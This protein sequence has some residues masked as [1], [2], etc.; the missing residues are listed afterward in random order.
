MP[1]SYSPQSQ[2]AKR[3]VR[4]TN[5]D[6]NPVQFQAYSKTLLQ[7]D[8]CNLHYR[9]GRYL[10]P[11]RSAHW[12]EYYQ[13]AIWDAVAREDGIIRLERKQVRRDMRD[14]VIGLKRGVST[15]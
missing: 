8:V 13:Q 4:F 9:L 14:D 7:P 5:D 3:H 6:D 11:V 1:H 10:F 2:P 12:P 15:G